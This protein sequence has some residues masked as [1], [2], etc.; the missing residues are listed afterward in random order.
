MKGFEL[1]FVKVLFII[2]F[3]L[4]SFM[5]LADETPF[6]VS[7]P[8]NSV[9]QAETESSEDATP[10]LLS[11]LKQEAIMQWLRQYLGNKATRYEKLITAKFAEGYILDYKVAQKGANKEIVELSGHLDTE[12]LKGWLRLAES[13]GQEGGQIRPT[14][15]MTDSLV[16]FTAPN[17]DYLSQTGSSVYTQTS[18]Q[19]LNQELKRLNLKLNPASEHPLFPPPRDEKGMSRL[20][21]S[22]SMNG[23]NAVVW[24]YLNKCKSCESPRLDIYLYSLERNGSLLSL[25]SEELP[26]TLKQL[27]NADKTKTALSPLFNQFQQDFERA[28]AEG[29]FSAL[30]LTITVEGIDNY[31]GYRKIDYALSKQ[32]YFSDWLPKT[33]VQNTAQF[34][35]MSNLTSDEVAQRIETLGL[36]EGK[37]SLVRVDSRNIIVRYSR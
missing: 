31:L 6:S 16:D 11:K 28:I 33:F 15:I 27:D 21:E 10:A 7:A 18:I 26:L 13:K 24:L 12:A 1:N 25:I 37:L 3:S 5:L 9:T 14:L 30:P 36:G 35:A 8:L 20:K 23:A 22:L 19:V 17:P 29:K 2:F 34:E 4:S 32:S